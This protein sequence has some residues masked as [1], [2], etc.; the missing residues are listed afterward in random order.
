MSKVV[1]EGWSLKTI[2]DVC[3]IA[4]GGTPSRANPEYWDT[5]KTTNNLW[6]SI[7]DLNGP[8]V[9][10]TLEYITDSGVKNSNVKLVKKGTV[11]MSF[12]LTVG[13]VAYA[14]KDLYTNEAIVALSP[15]LKDRLSNQ[16]L[17]QGLQYWDLLKDVDQA[18]KGVT[19][20]KDKINQIEALIPPI[21]EQQ[22]I[23]TILSSVDNVIEKTRT[24]IDK[25]KDL[26][27]GM[28]QELLTKGIGHTEFKDSS[29]GR[30]PKAWR[31]C[32]LNSIAKVIDSLHSTPKFSS[33]GYPMIRV[34]DIKP[35]NV[36]ID[37]ALRVSEEVFR[38][39]TKKYK[40]AKGDLLLS[41]VG[42]YG[43]CSYIN[44]DVELCIGQNTVVIVPQ[45][46]DGQ[47]LYH[48]VNSNYFQKQVELEVAGSGYKSLSLASIRAAT[49]VVP[50][51]LEQKEIADF[52]QAMDSKIIV[53]NQKLEALCNVKKSLMRLLLTGGIRV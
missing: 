17:Y 13:R 21:A 43:V 5:G 34:S 3:D 31:L 26:K 42:S 23:A 7:R 14:G 39:F 11:L 19:L 33:S 28:M 30:I 50:S 52:L 45:E 40:P 25:L 22:K 37:R 35:G 24:Q 49:I 18:V 4:I 53:F 10:E 1:P 44:R 8:W 12:K 2:S 47:F 41:R 51:K 48:A 46:I 36:Q 9:Y 38:E 15:K 32:S 29:V 16:F 27:T 20:N 6:V